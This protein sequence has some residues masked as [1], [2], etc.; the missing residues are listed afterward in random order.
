MKR[1]LLLVTALIA[2][3]SLSA[4]S[5]AADVTW[6]DPTKLNPNLVNTGIFASEPDYLYSTRTGPAE[7]GYSSIYIDKVSKKALNAESSFEIYSPTMYSPDVKVQ[8]PLQF[9][10]VIKTQDGF[11]AFFTEPDYVKYTFT[12]YCQKFDNTGAKVGNLVQLQIFQ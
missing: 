1:R 7:Y 9:N 5:Q 8:R 2:G 3:L 4:Y 11:I 10:E 6:G 12:S